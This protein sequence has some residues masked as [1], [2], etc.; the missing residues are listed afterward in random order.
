MLQDF[1]TK[2]DGNLF[3]GSS[4]TGHFRLEYKCDIGYEYDFSN[5][6]RILTI[7][8][9][10]ANIVLKCFSSTDQQQGEARAL[11]K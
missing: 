6:E 5:G 11:G 1:I 2:L 10:H 8:L 3:A 7:I 9:W 4:L